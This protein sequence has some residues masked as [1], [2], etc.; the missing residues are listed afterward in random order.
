MSLVAGAKQSARLMLCSPSSTRRLF[1]L[2]PIAAIQHCNFYSTKSATTVQKVTQPRTQR[3]P[4]EKSFSFAQTIEKQAHAPPTALW[5]RPHPISYQPKIANNFSF[6][7]SVSIPVKFVTDS[8]GKHFTVAVVSLAG[9]GRRASLS[10]PVVFEGDLAHVAAYHVKENDCVFV[11]GQLSVDP[12]RCLSSEI[13]GKFHVMA[14]S[15]NF[16]EGIEKSDLDTRL[17]ISYPDVEIEELGRVRSRNVDDV[18]YNQISQVESGGAKEIPLYEAEAVTQQVVAVDNG[19]VDVSHNSWEGAAKKKDTNQ[20]LDLWGDLVKQPL[21]WWDYR[22]HKANGLVKEKYPDF[23]KKGTWESLWLSSAPKWIL[24]TL[25]KLEF[26]V[27]EMKVEKKVYGGEG[28]SERKQ[29]TDPNNSW[30]DLVENPGKWWDNRAGKKNSKA[31]DFRH[32]ETGEVLWLNRSPD[33][34]LSK[35]PPVRGGQNTA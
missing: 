9:D 18:D 7:G 32:K 8:D 17:V 6:I 30:E 22:S 10:I 26:D 14:E 16:V 24:P 1:H 25:G 15:V 20:I 4:T 35:L 23:K 2:H 12:L 3:K 33:W 21:D 28:F 19:N 29:N 27:K 5:P 34:V 13:L 31:P 11:S